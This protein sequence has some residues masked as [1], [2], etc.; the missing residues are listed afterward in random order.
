MGQDNFASGFMAGA[1]LGGIIGGIVGVLATSKLNRRA[2]ASSSFGTFPEGTS[3]ADMTAEER[4]ETARRGLEDKIAQ[5]NLAIEDVR[6]QMG[7]VKNGHP[8]SERE[9]SP[10][11]DS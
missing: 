2:A 9:Q 3:P 5:L 1:F 8:P 7:P 11:F 6:Q 10:Q 4:M